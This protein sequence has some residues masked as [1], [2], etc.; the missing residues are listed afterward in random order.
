MPNK[1][2]NCKWFF[3]PQ[4]PG[5][6]KGPNDPT[7]LRFKGTPIHSL[8][9]ESI[10]NSLDARDNSNDD[11]VEVSF[12]Y[13]EFDAFE[14]PRFF[15]LKDH[16]E[17]CLKK[18]PQDE[19]GKKLFGPML[20]HFPVS[21]LDQRIGYLRVR[22][23]NT[24]GM[25][26]NPNDP[27]S[28]F[29]CFISEGN[30]SKPD[31]AGGSFGF[32]KAVFWMY[33]P[34]KTVFVS[35]RTSDNEINFVGQSKLCTHYDKEGNDL[36]PNGL[37][38]T[39][40]DGKVISNTNNIPDEF[41]TKEQGTSVF[42]LGVHFLGDNTHKE[43]VAA[44]LRNFWMSIMN[45]QLVVNIEDQVI[46]AETLPTLMETYFEEKN[47]LE[48]EIHKYNPHP[49]YDLVVKAKANND[50]N[51]KVINDTIQVGDKKWTVSLYL[52]LDEEA[53][54]HV[55]YMRSPLMTICCQKDRQF[56][57]AEGVFVCADEEGNGFLREMEDFAHD[58]WT[59]E[60]YLARGNN[61][62]KLAKKVLNTIREFISEAVR[63][64]LHSDEQEVLQVNGLEDLLYI[65][66]SND[67]QKSS[68]EDI[69]DPNS[70]VEPKTPKK[71][72]QYKPSVH[73]TKQT[74]A[75]P[76]ENG[77]LRSNRG[78]KRHRRFIPG[79]IKPGD[80]KNKATENENGKEGFYAT[81]VDV[82]YRTWSQTEEDHIWHIIRIDSNE[83]ISN[84]LI[85]V[86]AVKEDG[87]IQ[88][89][90]IEQ[91]VGYVVRNGEEFVDAD[92]FEDTDEDSN[93]VKAQVNNAIQG[94]NIQA[95]V[96]TILKIR[97]NSDIKYSLIINSDK[98]ETITNE[99][100]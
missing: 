68:N 89:L 34:I 91:A 31:G 64:A 33:S 98:L 45:K 13:K 54:G 2:K 22:D 86:Y 21:L 36:S 35:S 4:A 76:D 55:V 57:G 25:S 96:P 100:K 46:N 56:K 6:E 7:T 67:V 48:N 83:A 37:Y 9:R 29:N 50:D 84:A 61:D 97:F 69:I 43:M 12:D 41:L 82:N 79:P 51:Y 1:E 71:V 94:V 20:N 60:N 32:G 23:K 85:Q 42:V 77:K 28:A 65:A 52:H 49:Y 62:K 14:Y 59:V 15:D 66:T 8:I 80:L 74:K 39:E 30:A 63:S 93:P 70:I 38:S 40:G 88:G 92:N 47:N 17:G 24:T 26:Y 87:T 78:G 11:P 3:G 72:K 18:Y 73:R 5:N 90:N 95:N 27:K 81:P 58:S 19:N 10:Q 99:N 16:I 53:K 75:V 44:V